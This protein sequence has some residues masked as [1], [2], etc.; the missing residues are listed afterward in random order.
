MEY[1]ELLEVLV[2]ERCAWVRKLEGSF[3]GFIKKIENLR[4]DGVGYNVDF[5]G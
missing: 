2:R 3:V 5:N 1:V 4:L